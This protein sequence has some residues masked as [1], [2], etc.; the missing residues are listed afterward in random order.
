MVGCYSTPFETGTRAERA[1]VLK[2]NAKPYRVAK[3]AAGRPVLREVREAIVP[4]EGR[5]AVLSTVVV[6][7]I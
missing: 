2:E 5:G 3:Y 6:C 4:G 7:R 1:R